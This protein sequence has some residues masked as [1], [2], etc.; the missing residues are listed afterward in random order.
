[1]SVIRML[2]RSAASRHL[3]RGPLVRTFTAS[4]IVSK[5]AP[6]AAQ[7]KT[8]L[9]TPY[10]ALTVGIP[11]ET[12][13]LEKRVAASPESVQR[14]V[15]PGFSVVVERDAGAASHFSNADYQAAG[16][17]VVDNVWQKSDIVLKVSSILC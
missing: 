9:G 10:S 8:P 11:K 6:D 5:D 4:S 3:G 2:S 15:K 16:A 1:M 14:L 12:F 17:Q 13:P 7:K